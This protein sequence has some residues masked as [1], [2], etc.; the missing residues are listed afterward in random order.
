ML[1]DGDYKPLGLN[2][3][4]VYVYGSPT[5][6]QDVIEL[7]FSN[8]ITMDEAGLK[9]LAHYL[10]EE[11]IP[12]IEH[13]NATMALSELEEDEEIEALLGTDDYEPYG[14]EGDDES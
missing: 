7:D 8:L 9:E 11:V 13:I 1:C 12:S 4:G 2:H 5:D 6:D 14:F 10:L 3:A